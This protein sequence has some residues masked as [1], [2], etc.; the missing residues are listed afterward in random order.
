[1]NTTTEILSLL[2]FGCTVAWLYILIKVIKYV[3]EMKSENERLINQRDLITSAMLVSMRSECIQD[4]NYEMADKL[5]KCLKD[6]SQN[7][8]TISVTDKPN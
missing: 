8:I 6:L 2:N 5:T 3:G 1:M 7:N 4:E